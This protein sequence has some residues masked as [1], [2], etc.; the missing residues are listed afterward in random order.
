[1]AKIL[2]AGLINYETTVLVEKFPIDY[3]PVRYPFFGV[4]S[5]I[6]GVGYN[7]AKALTSLGDQVSL[8]SLIGRDG[9]GELI[10]A[11]IEKGDISPVYL[12]KQLSQSVQSVILYDQQG[13][14]QIN[15]DLKEIQEESYP[16]H[17]IEEVI[18]GFE[19]AVLCNINFS[20]PF[21][22]IARKFSL[23]VATD[24]HAISSLDD[25]YN[26]DYISG[27]NILFMSHEQL[28]CSADDFLRKIL[29]R[30][31]NQIVVAGLG[32]QGALLA[33]RED[34]SIV[35]FPAVYT[36]P[37]VNTIGAGD[38]LFS[39][40]IHSYMASG[41]PYQAMKDAIV[42]SSYKIGENGGANGF[43]D[44]DSLRQLVNGIFC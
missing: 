28:P 9:I 37:V 18:Q 14:R 11:E 4:N 2:V 24:V 32:S 7:V 27:A 19:I 3:S 17:V 35:H 33:L 25:E 43:L 42:F 15:L 6:S 16:T 5:T 12:R 10:Y 30:Y 26:R 22:R 40:F 31:N 44:G 13:K 41:D 34:Q 23:P 1:M 39:C 8:F 20:R 29:Q 38:A 36:R 21:L